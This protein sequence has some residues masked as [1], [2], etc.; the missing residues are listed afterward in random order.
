VSEGRRFDAVLFDAGGVL[1]LPDGTVL[2]PL[3]A[4]YGGSLELA[5]HRWAHYVAMHA[6]DVED[7]EGWHAY[8]V[9]YVRSVGVPAHDL[10][11]AVDVFRLTFTSMLWRYPNE[12]AT[13]TLAALAERHV[14]I[15]VVSNASGQIEDVLTR[16]GIC[17]V[18]EGRGATVVC[19]VDSHV[20]GVAKPDPRIFSSALADLGVAPDRVAYVGDSV[21]YD[22]HGARAAGLVPVLLDPH[23]LSDGGGHDR[24]AALTDLLAWV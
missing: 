22:V 12:G 15:G 7:V 14:P 1:V 10:D 17:Q 5:D 19:V 2:G 18:G 9:T 4:P 20:V 11:H 23:R 3:L 21:R 16:T 13:E 8:H 6:H 24:I